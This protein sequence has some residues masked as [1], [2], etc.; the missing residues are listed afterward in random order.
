MNASN[1]TR[2]EHG[3]GMLMYVRIILKNKWIYTSVPPYVFM[4]WCPI[5]HRDNFAFCKWVSKPVGMQDE[6]ERTWELK[7]LRL[8][9]WSV[10]AFK[11][12]LCCDSRPWH[13]DCGVR[14]RVVVITDTFS[15]CLRLA[16]LS[17][18][19]KNVCISGNGIIWHIWA[20]KCAVYLSRSIWVLGKVALK[21]TLSLNTEK[22]T[23]EW[24]N[25]RSKELN[26]S[27]PS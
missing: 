14:E 10:R 23:R 5:Y 7:I 19:I 16:W 8:F 13:I 20:W 18:N 17:D 26:T 12:P 11:L 1:T 21:K 4:V 27:Y 24:W 2:S 3:R 15:C 25:L 22:V 6:E 9:S